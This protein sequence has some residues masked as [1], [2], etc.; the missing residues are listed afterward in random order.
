MFLFTISQFRSL[1]VELS[2]QAQKQLTAAEFISAAA[3]RNI[4]VS[5]MTASLLANDYDVLAQVSKVVETQE[6]VAA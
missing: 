3:Q 5:Q 1:F 2:F 6:L 4:Y